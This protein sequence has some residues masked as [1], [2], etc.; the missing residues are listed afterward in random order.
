MI[1][2]NNTGM[3]SGNTQAHEIGRSKINHNFHTRSVHMKCYS[4]D[5]FIPLSPRSDQHQF[6][7]NN[8]SI[9]FNQVERL[10]ELIKWSLQGNMPWSLNKFSQP[11]FQELYGGQCGEFP[12]W[13]ITYLFGLKS[14]RVYSRN[15]LIL[16]LFLRVQLP[17]LLLFCR[18][19]FFQERGVH[20]LPKI[21]NMISSH[22][23]K[24]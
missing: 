5:L 16:L 6:S 22:T 15:W 18:W 10:W 9:N 20:I 12:C 14:N 11:S 8:I 4:R 23:L 21:M 3:Q 24:E 2:H 13:S 1:L 19:L 17:P 7:Q